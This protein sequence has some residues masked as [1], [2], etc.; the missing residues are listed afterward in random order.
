MNAIDLKLK[1]I[2]AGLTQQQLAQKI[3]VKETFITRLETD[4]KIITP[5]IKKQLLKALKD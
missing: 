5:D 1:R 4:R 3:G 2:K